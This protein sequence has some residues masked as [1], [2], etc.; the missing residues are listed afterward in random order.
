MENVDCVSSII[1][2]KIREGVK[3]MQCETTRT[4]DKQGALM[5]CVLLVLHYACIS[6]TFL[7]SDKSEHSHSMEMGSSRS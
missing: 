5:S 3:D 2:A 6:P 4:F 1:L 7:L